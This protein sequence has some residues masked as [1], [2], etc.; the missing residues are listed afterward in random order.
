MIKN[1]RAP[2][3]GFFIYWFDL[4]G[5][6]DLLDELSDFPAELSVLL[7]ELADGSEVL[8]ALDELSEE[9]ELELPSELLDEASLFSLLAGRFSPEVDL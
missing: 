5:L 8:P 1:P 3:R 4:P 7:L 2:A 9:L 6:S